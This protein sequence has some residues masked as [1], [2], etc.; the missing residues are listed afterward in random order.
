MREGGWCAGVG[1]CVC[2]CGCGMVVGDEGG[3]R[4][5]VISAGEF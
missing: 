1:V 4:V 5:Q 3:A 2:V